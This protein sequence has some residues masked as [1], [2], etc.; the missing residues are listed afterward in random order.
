MVNS[1]WFKRSTFFEIFNF[2]LCIAVAMIDL[3]HDVD[4]IHGNTLTANST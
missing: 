3:A 2:V 1:V 4:A